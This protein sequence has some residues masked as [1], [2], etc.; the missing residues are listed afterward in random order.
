MNN[1]FKKYDMINQ[2]ENI[3]ELPIN[4]NKI[5]KLKVFNNQIFYVPKD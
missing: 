3:S 4:S 5:E 2:N 1:S